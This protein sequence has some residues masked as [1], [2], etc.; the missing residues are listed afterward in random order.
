[1]SVL[2]PSVRLLKLGKLAP[3]HFRQRWRH[4]VFLSFA[5]CC[6][7][8]AQQ[9]GNLANRTEP[10]KVPLKSHL[11]VIDILTENLRRNAVQESIDL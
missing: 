10:Q 3:R 7:V 6:L 1:M 9:K 11:K 8:L 2:R 5:T 4:M